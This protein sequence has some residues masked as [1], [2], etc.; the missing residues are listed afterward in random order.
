MASNPLSAGFNV[1]LFE[2]KA[3]APLTVKPIITPRMNPKKYANA[4]ALR[5]AL[6][7]RQFD[8]VQYM[9]VAKSKPFLK[10]YRPIH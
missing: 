5:K 1:S 9:A 3:L 6:P 7:P 8:P 2:P 4:N 10:R